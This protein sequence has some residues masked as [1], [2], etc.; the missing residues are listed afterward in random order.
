MYDVE[1]S[2]SNPAAGAPGRSGRGGRGQPRP[3]VFY[4]DFPA[5]VTRPDGSFCIRVVRRPYSEFETAAEY[6]VRQEQRWMELTRRYQLCA[7]TPPPARSPAAQAADY[8]RVLG[9]DL[10][11]RPV[12]RIQP[13]FMLA[14]QLAYLESGSRLAVSFQHPTPLGLLVVDAASEV[15]VDWGDGGAVEGPFD[16]VGAPWPAGRITH[17][18]TETRTY[19][20]RV[21][22]R[23][24]AR[25]RLGAATGELEGL[26]TEGLIDDFP[27][28][29]LQAVIN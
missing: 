5:L 12:P 10:L 13:G 16:D 25:W 19:D 2:D 4:G 26:V 27:V 18:W 29:E 15:W 17:Y 23:W 1:G 7:G 6:E 21:Y 9:E 20:I 14:G 3:E 11:P 8:W 24:S 22:Q 28:R